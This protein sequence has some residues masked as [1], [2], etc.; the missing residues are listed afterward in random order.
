MDAGTSISSPGF[1]DF[2]G[3]AIPRGNAIDIGAHESPSSGGTNP[4]ALLSNGGFA[5]GLTGWNCYPSGC[6]TTTSNVSTGG[7]AAQI[8]GADRGVYRTVSGLTPNTTYVL[9]AWLAAGSSGQSGYLYVKNYGGSQINAAPVT[10][11]SYTRTSLSFTTGPSSTTA[12]IGVWRDQNAGSGSLFVDD[13]AL[14]VPSNMLSNPGFEDGTL[15]GWSCF[16]SGCSVVSGDPRTGTFSASVTDADRGLY[17]TVSGLSPSTTYVWS[18]WLKSQTSGQQGY[19]YVKPA[20]SSQVNS[21]VITA[22]GSYTQVTVA[23]T[24]GPGGT[25]AEVGFW[26]DAGSGSGAILIDDGS[27]LI[28]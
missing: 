11:T 23:F 9:S 25:S 12:E 4:G 5:N 16:P 17:Q 24:T 20:G 26:R 13:V 3:N 10:S 7:G 18:A 15:S 1:S 6:S 21:S 19:L 14:V 27:L 8:T 28:Q 22:T 2:Y